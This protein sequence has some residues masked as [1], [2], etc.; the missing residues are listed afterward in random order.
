MGRSI[1]DTDPGRYIPGGKE[2]K[3]GNKEMIYYGFTIRREHDH[4]LVLDQ[5][6]KE[7]GRYD[8]VTDAKQDIRKELEIDD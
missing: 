8:T 1:I 5:T 3:L 2:K 6:G 4:I 7:F